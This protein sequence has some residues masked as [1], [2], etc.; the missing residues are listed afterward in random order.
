MEQ[1]A[2]PP[3]PEASIPP[4]HIRISGTVVQVMAPDTAQ[5]SG[6]CA[7]Y[8]CRAQVRVDSVLGYG[9]GVTVTLSAGETVSVYFPFTLEPT[10]QV[11]PELQVDLP[12]LQLG[13]RFRADLAVQG[14]GPG[15]GEVTFV[16]YHYHVQPKN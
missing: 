11:R 5:A 7:R 16:V 12:G 8:A 15:G 4:G 13:D 14:P 10:R 1:Q 3:S 9:S 6:V 2:T